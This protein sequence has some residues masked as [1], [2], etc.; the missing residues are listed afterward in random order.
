MK[1][2]AIQNGQGNT[3]KSPEGKKESIRKW[4]DDLEQAALRKENTE[5]V[6]VKRQT[7]WLTTEMKIIVTVRCKFCVI[8]ATRVQKS[9]NGKC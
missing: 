5:P 8:R 7:F 6:L 2:H 4:A 3:I 1:V 9:G